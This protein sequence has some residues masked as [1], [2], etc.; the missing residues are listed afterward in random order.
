MRRIL[1]CAALAMAVAVAMPGAASAFRGGGGHG[2]GGH[3]GGGW[4]WRGGWLL[5]RLSRLLRA[6]WL[7]AMGRLALLASRV[8]VLLK[9]SLAEKRPA[10][11]GSLGVTT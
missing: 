5:R 1:V 4:G 10:G 11:G 7:L 3:W 8:G 2:F 9:Q 6:L